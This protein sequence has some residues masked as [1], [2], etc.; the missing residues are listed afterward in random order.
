MAASATRKQPRQMSTNW[1]LLPATHATRLFSTLGSADFAECP[2][3]GV[4][5]VP[6]KP[7]EMRIRPPKKAKLRKRALLTLTL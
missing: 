1:V 5:A 7:A 4:V 3:A 6:A 2:P